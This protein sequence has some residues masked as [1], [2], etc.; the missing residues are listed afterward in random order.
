VEYDLDFYFSSE[1]I[2][3]TIDRV[4]PRLPL[5]LFFVFKLFWGIPL[6]VLWKAIRNKEYYFVM[7]ILAILLCDLAQLVIAYDVTR[8]LCLGFPAL[9]ISAKKLREYWPD[10]RFTRI[11]LL[12]LLLNLITPQYFMTCDGLVWLP[13]FFLQG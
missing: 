6:I 7:V 8:M 5:G 3:F 12:L 10:K 9:L 11:L 1:N 13:P 4:V 2:R